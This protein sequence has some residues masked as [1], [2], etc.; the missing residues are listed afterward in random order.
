[1][2][3]QDDILATSPSASEDPLPPESI[4]VQLARI[5]RSRTFSNA[6]TLGPVSATIWL[7]ILSRAMRTA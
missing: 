7:S 5:L 2:D 3:Q 6:P 1:M 4:R